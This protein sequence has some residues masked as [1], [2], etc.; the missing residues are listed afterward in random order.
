MKIL[1]AVDGSACSE[2]AARHVA[3]RPWPDGTQVEILSAYEHPT[4]LAM[5]EVPAA[6]PEYYEKLEEGAKG[7]AQAAVERARS[8]LTRSAR[9]LAVS[10][11]LVEGPA[12]ASILEEAE[13]WKADLIVVGSHGYSAF[14]R[15]WLGSVSH[16]VVAHARC[17]V[18]VVRAE[19]TSS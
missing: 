14:T 4:L 12:K 7:S 16:A 19:Q 2:A 11:K 10:A 8:L 17:S 18:L 15:L 6:P 5:P 1:L 9:N 3:A 13:R